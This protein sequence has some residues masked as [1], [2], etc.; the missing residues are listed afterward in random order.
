MKHF[1]RGLFGLVILLAFHQWW[2]H[3]QTLKRLHIP[4]STALLGD[5]RTL[6]AAQACDAKGLDPYRDE[7]CHV[8]VARFNYPRVWIHVVAVLGRVADPIIL[9]G[10]L[11]ALAVMLTL[12]ALA[13]RLQSNWPVLLLFSPPVLLLLERGNIEGIAMAATFLPL[14]CSRRWAWV[15]VLAGFA[16]KLFPAAACLCWS[17]IRPRGQAILMG[18]VLSV[19]MFL[20]W[21]DIMAMLNNTPTGCANAF[22]LATMGDCIRLQGAPKL[23]L[24]FGLVLGMAFCLWWGRAWIRARQSLQFGPSPWGRDLFLMSGAIYAAVFVFSASWAYRFVFLL[25]AVSVLLASPNRTL[26]PLAWKGAIV[27]F[28]PFLPGGW[29][30][31]NALNLSLFV[32][33]VVLVSTHFLYASGESEQ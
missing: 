33:L 3:E 1:V 15:G 18:V 20:Q 13:S 9:L 29:L 27:A 30:L 14:L 11:N 26:R 24:G 32:T 22:G 28:V 4:M 17:E 19:A 23:M 12:S 16:L 21:E 25:P 31:F 7:S 5:I 8:G 6:T 2:G 10:V